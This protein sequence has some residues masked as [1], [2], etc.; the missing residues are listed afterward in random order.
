MITLRRITDSKDSAFQKLTELYKEAFPQEE[1]REIAQLEQLLSGEPLMYFN[2]VECDGELAGLFVYWD[3]GSFYYLEH[4]AVYAEMRNKKIGQQVLDW[5]K[6][7]LQ[8][9][10]LLEAEP[11]ETEMST[12]RI[13]YYQRNGYQILDKDY[14]QPPYTPEGEG[15]PLWVMGN[16]AD[17][18]AEVLQQ[19]IE[20]IKNKIYYRK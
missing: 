7:H 12:R 16:V 6:E 3:L 15:F 20:T 18:P 5:M 4:L 14:L 8:G 17:Q 11:A 13:N 2:A 10:R 1:R 9:V 19:Q